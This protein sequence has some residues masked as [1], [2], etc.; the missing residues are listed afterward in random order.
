[1]ISRT[2]KKNHWAGL[3]ICFRVCSS[4]NSGEREF[5]TQ[6]GDSIPNLKTNVYDK[7]PLIKQV[8][9]SGLFSFFLCLHFRLWTAW[10]LVLNVQPTDDC[11]AKSGNDFKRIHWLTDL[12]PIS[13]S[14]YL[15]PSN[16]L[17]LY[18][19]VQAWMNQ[20]QAVHHPVEASYDLVISQ[21]WVNPK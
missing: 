3:G 20:Q 10:R 11:Q 9:Y 14:S 18:A 4:V 6:F 15:L 1:M 13:F 17:H 21:S 16:L 8:C 7:N 12:L 5:K 19:D 2:K